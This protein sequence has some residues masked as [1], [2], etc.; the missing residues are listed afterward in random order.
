[1]AEIKPE[2]VGTYKGAAL[3]NVVAY[4]TSQGRVHDM[5]GRVVPADSAS[6]FYIGEQHNAIVE[7]YLAFF[8]QAVMDNY[9]RH[10]PCGIC[11]L[12]LKALGLYKARIAYLTA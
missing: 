12:Y 7:F 1:M 10:G 3:A 9:I 8:Y 4:K 5:R 2:A 11:N 6:A